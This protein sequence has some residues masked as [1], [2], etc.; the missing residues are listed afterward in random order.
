MVACFPKSKK[1]GLPLKTAIKYPYFISLPDK[2]YFFMTGIWT[3]WTDKNTGEYVESFAI[4]TTKTNKLMEQV[5]ISKKRM[6][7]ILN[8]DLAYKWMFIKL[9]EKRITEIATTQY[10]AN[11]MSA[12]SV[13]KDFITALDHQ[14]PFEYADLLALE[15]V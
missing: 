12:C 4:V 6:P 2:E 5:H 9:D 14:Q 7:T 8:E 3:S 11:E 15:I 10:P 1:I 13:A